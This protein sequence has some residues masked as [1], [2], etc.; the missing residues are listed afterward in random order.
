MTSLID[1]STCRKFAIL[2]SAICLGFSSAR[3]EKPKDYTQELSGTE[4]TFDMVGIPAG[5]FVIG[6]PE[7]E[8]DRNDDEGQHQETEHPARVRG[9]AN[10]AIGTS[11]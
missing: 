1:S 6:S 2:L 11:P 7:G 3:A 10:G 9:P 5:E 8:A 4:V